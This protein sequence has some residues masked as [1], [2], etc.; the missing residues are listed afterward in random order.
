MIVL[1]TLVLL[2]CAHRVCCGGA[3]KRAVTE[4][5]ARVT[6]TPPTAYLALDESDVPPT[7]HEQ[8]GRTF[9]GDVQAGVEEARLAEF[10]NFLNE[11]QEFADLEDGDGTIE[12]A[13]SSHEL[14]K[15]TPEALRRARKANPPPTAHQTLDTSEAVSPTNRETWL[16][17]IVDKTPTITKRSRGR[18]RAAAR[19]DTGNAASSATVHAPTEEAAAEAGAEAEA[20][21]EAEAMPSWKAEIVERHAKRIVERRAKQA[22]EQAMPSKPEALLGLGTALDL[23]AALGDLRVEMAAAPSSSK[24]LDCIEVLCLP[25]AHRTGVLC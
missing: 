4:A 23:R 18:E 11:H 1:G 5:R 21:A 20:E 2:C 24:Q 12:I 8:E 22:L 14:E 15:I 3:A 13:R 10:Q 17:E 7:Y 6:S 9:G 16:A 19:R 25:H